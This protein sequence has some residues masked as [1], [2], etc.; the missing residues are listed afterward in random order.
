MNL[1]N[2]T[3]KQASV[4]LVGNK[5]N[6]QDFVASKKPLVLSED[7]RYI[8]KDSF[9]G[10]FSYDLDRYSFHH[11]A[12]LDYNQVYNYCL[13]ALADEG[14]FHKNSVNIA[15]HLYESSVHP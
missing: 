13:E 7:D 2:A 12:S 11:P 9:L 5:G 3:L 4:H 14:T 10:K 1:G 6:G 8:L 15:K